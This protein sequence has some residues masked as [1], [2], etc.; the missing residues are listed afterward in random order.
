MRGTKQSPTYRDCA[1]I[2]VVANYAR[3]VLILPSVCSLPQGL[4][5]FGLIQKIKTE[6]CFSAQGH[7]MTHVSVG[8]SLASWIVLFANRPPTS[9]NRL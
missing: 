2:N 6:K 1:L 8:P 9:H 7:R 5:T 4:A 3:F